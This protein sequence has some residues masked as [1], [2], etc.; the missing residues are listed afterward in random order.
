ME[1]LFSQLQQLDLDLSP[2][3]LT[4]C[5]N[6]VAYFCTP[7]GAQI[8]GWAGVDGIHYCTV[9]VFGTM[10]FA[11]SPMNF[12]D[13]VHPIARNLHDLL[14]LLLSCGTMDA[15]EQCY[16]WDRAQFD[17]YLMD[18][19]ST[20]AQQRILDTLRYALDLEP[21]TDAFT[22]VKKLQSEFD[23]NRIPYPR[24]YYDPDMNAA[25]PP[26]PTQWKVTYD[27]GFRSC[28]GTAGEAISVEK[29]FFWGDEKWYIPAIYL[30]N[31]GL[32]IDFFKEVAPAQLS[33]FMDKWDLRNE[34]HNQY[35]QE[36]QEQIQ[37]ENPLD[38]SFRGHVTLNGQKLQSDHGWSIS[39]LPPAY[40]P[41]NT[42]QTP[43]AALALAHYGLNTN[44]AW[45]I[46]RK[47]YRWGNQVFT[48]I[49]S[50]SVRMER[51]AERI[52]GMVFK[53]PS[54][55]ESLSLRHPLTGEIY[56]L[57]VHDVQQQTLP[58]QAFPDPDTEYPSHFLMLQYS[59]DPDLSVRDFIIQDCF[60]GDTPRKKRSDHSDAHTHLSEASTG[61]IGGADGPTAITFGSVGTKYHTACSSGRFSPA[62]AVNWRCLFRHKPVKDI[63][64]SLI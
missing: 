16:C 63:T 39:W 18:Y 49:P 40:L 6:T 24:D 37:Q 27:G 36:Q 15:L 21:M 43:E 59:L 4:Q 57:T 29:T 32:V 33:A 52:A 53:T 17:G 46:H 12:G 45:A 30:C 60:Q 11:V 61:I 1:P 20:P 64:V 2:L 26:P 42:R 3:G 34:A 5:K 7:E 62:E 9:P 23:L 35:T 28:D 47:S 41:D 50:L 51:T 55:G 54:S 48:D 56:T 25:P 22:Y 8:I 13:C 14:C 38:I 44:Q 19:P 10:I 58:A 31:N